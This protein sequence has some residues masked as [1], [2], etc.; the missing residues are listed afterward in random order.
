MWDVDLDSKRSEVCE[1]L[2]GRFYVRGLL[3]NQLEL[4]LFFFRVAFVTLTASVPCH[5]LCVI[6]GDCI[7]IDVG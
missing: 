3:W 2:V 5:L 1:L 4:V 6:T 7:I